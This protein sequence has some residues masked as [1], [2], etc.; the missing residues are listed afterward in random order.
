MDVM[1]TPSAADKTVGDSDASCCAAVSP[2]PAVSTS[3]VGRM[4]TSS[5]VTF[6]FASVPTAILDSIRVRLA[7]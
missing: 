7:V 2:S 1:G 5:A 4:L 3:L 6:S